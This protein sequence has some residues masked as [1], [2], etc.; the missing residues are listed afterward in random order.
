MHCCECV[1]YYCASLTFQSFSNSLFDPFPTLFNLPLHS[2]FLFIPPS[3]QEL[4][5]N[6]LTVHTRAVLSVD[7]DLEGDECL[8]LGGDIT[9]AFTAMPTVPGCLVNKRIVA[10]V[11][12]TNMDFIGC[13]F[14]PLAFTFSPAVPNHEV[15]IIFTFINMFI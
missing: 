2:S 8:E 10:E 7:H 5:I 4:V 3:S 14:E 13:V 15:G 12:T 1:V 6:Q 9:P 11:G